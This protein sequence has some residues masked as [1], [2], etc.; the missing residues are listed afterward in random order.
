MQSWAGP[1]TWEALQE[2]FAHFDK[3]DSWN[4]LEKTI[5]LFR[6]LAQKTAEQLEND[7]STLQYPDWFQ[8]VMEAYEKS[9]EKRGAE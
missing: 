4:A 6:N 7:L 3:Q 1:S 5:S 2:C 8:S 9:I